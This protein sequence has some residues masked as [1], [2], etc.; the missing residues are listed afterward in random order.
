MSVH[1]NLSKLP[2]KAILDAAYE[3][4]LE[5][6]EFRSLLH[7]ELQKALDNVIEDEQAL[8]ISKDVLGQTIEECYAGEEDKED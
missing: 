7:P 8:G 6:R 2:P 1:L 4:I 3:L 5:R